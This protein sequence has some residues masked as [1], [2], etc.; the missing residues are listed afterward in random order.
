MTTV[1]RHIGGYR[2]AR[3]SSGVRRIRLAQGLAT[4]ALLALPSA[5]GAAAGGAYEQC[6]IDALRRAADADTVSTLRAQCAAAAPPV[7]AVPAEPGTT[8]SAGATPL[9]AAEVPRADIDAI[10]ATTS[11]IEAGQQREANLWSQRL[12][13]LPHRPNFF[14]PFAYSPDLS[15]TRGSTSPLQSTE[16]KFQLSFKMPLLDPVGERGLTAWFAYT[17]QSWWQA[18]NSERSSPFRE[19]NHEPEL[20]V[21]R[22]MEVPLG[23]WTL[24]SIS[25]G[26]VHQSNG[27]AQPLSRSWNRLFAEFRLDTPQRWWMVVRPW[28]R[29]RETNKS[30]LDQA[31]GDDNPD[32]GRYMGNGE[33]RF[34]YAGGRWRGSAMIRRSL[35]SGGKG[36]AQL[37]LSFP[38]G[39]SP[40]VRWYVQYFDGY[41]ESLIDYNRRVSRLSFGVLLNDWF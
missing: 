22:V 4:C 29:V 37:D 12:G 24:R 19:Y 6:L 23:P 15:G 32:I 26:F 25:G 17:G 18:Y 21:S 31:A 16:F 39:F 3:G 40:L 2:V 9:P 11:V 13:I 1:G 41:G 36:A 20:F 27:R 28:V 7:P 8:G 14:L 35:Q 33:L 30:D 10:P 5:A 38:T 34:G